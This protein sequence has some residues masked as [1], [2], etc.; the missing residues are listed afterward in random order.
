MLWSTT[1]IDAILSFASKD[2]A[3]KIKSL[4]DELYEQRGSK[5]EA[6]LKKLNKK[7]SDELYKG[8]REILGAEVWPAVEELLAHLEDEAA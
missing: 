5:M 6:H 2:E 1:I 3:A 8:C 4:E 7:Y